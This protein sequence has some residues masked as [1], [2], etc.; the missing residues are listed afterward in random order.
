LDIEEMGM[1]ERRKTGRGLNERN[2]ERKKERRWP[3]VVEKGK[4][5]KKRSRGDW[6]MI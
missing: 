6:I 4:R 5:V 3:E 2:R 1:E